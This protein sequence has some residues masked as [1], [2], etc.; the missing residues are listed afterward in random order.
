MA[1]RELKVVLSKKSA[2]QIDRAIDRIDPKTMQ[3][4][5]LKMGQK[6]VN[7]VKVPVLRILVEV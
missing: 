5:G 7:G 6:T 2:I 4:K 3:L 1:K